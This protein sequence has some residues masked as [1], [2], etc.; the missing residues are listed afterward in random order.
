MIAAVF[1]GV[2][3]SVFWPMFTGKRLDA[4]MARIEVRCIDGKKFVQT[5]HTLRTNGNLVQ[6]IGDDG[7]PAVCN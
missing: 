1:L 3:A 2:L 5:E 4:Q 7:K 6:I